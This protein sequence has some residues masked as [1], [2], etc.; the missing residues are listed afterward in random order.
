MALVISSAWSKT[1]Q[2]SSRRLPDD[3]FR[4]S[5]ILEIEYWLPRRSANFPDRSW[6][7]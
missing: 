6:S 5:T 4:L 3:L 1:Y 7:P 2:F